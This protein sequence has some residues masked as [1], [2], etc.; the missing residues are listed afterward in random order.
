MPHARDDNSIPSVI[1]AITDDVGAATERNDK[2]TVA[3][4]FGGATAL[5]K[6]TQGSGCREQRVDGTLGYGVTMRLKKC[7]QPREI[8]A[9]PP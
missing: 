7:P 1:D 8:N 5:W 9:R 6:V 2:L 4:L 3:G